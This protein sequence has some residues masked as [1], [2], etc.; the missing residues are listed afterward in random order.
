MR[1]TSWEREGLPAV[2]QSL[3]LINES[4][5]KIFD[6]RGGRLPRADV[7]E[8]HFRAYSLSNV[9]DVL[10]QYAPIIGALGDEKYSR[11]IG[12]TADNAHAI[13]HHMFREV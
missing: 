11:E 5:P 4:I 3:T 6:E 7:E 9:A 8:H 12:N 10:E 13:A 1:P 2:G